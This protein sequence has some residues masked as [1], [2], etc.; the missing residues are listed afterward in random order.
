M[1]SV[2]NASGNPD[3]D[4]LLWGWRWDTSSISF[5][6][7]TGT[8]EYSSYAAINGFQAFESVAGDDKQGATRSILT[9]VSSFTNLTFNET[10]SSGALLRYAQATS[11]NYTNNSS[12]AGHTGLHTISTAESNPPELGYNG[13][14]PYSA[15][16]AWG[17]SWYNPNNYD[18]P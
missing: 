8:A 7:P 4:G 13:S 6:F 16:Y 9:N 2:V 14:A 11:I 12:V 5:S 3:I 10:T 17:D 15:S 1:V 18:N